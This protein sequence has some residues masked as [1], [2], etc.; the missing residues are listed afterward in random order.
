VVFALRYDIIVMKRSDQF[1]FSITL[2][3]TTNQDSRA[4]AGETER[5][6][7]KFRYVSNFTTES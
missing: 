5:C 4:I 6:W 7:C 1:P 3:Y 2:C